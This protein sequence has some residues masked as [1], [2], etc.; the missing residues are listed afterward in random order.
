MAK[1][2]LNY[3]KE[4]DI[5]NIATINDVGSI[6]FSERGIRVG[7]GGSYILYDGMSHENYNKKILIDFLTFPENPN[8]D[9]KYV[10]PNGKEWTYDGTKWQPSSGQN[11]D[12]YIDKTTGKEY[13]YVDGKWLNYGATGGINNSGGNTGGG[14]V[15]GTDGTIKIEDNTLYTVMINDSLLSVTTSIDSLIS[16]D[17]LAINKTQEQLLSWVFNG[18]ESIPFVSNLAIVYQGNILGYIEHRST[19]NYLQAK[20]VNTE[21]TLQEWL[22]TQGTEIQNNYDLMFVYP[23]IGIKITRDLG[24]LRIDYTRVQNAEGF[25]YSAFQSGYEADGTTPIYKDLLMVSVNGGKIK[26]GRYYSYPNGSVFAWQFSEN[27]PLSSQLPYISA[28]N[29]IAMLRRGESYTMMTCW[30][31]RFIGCI[32]ALVAKKFSFLNQKQYGFPEYEFQTHT[33]GLFYDN[34]NKQVYFDKT[35][36]N[37][38]KM[39]AATNAENLDI[40][41]QLATPIDFDIAT[42]G[43]D[44]T[45][46]DG[47]YYAIEFYTSDNAPNNNN[48]FA[49]WPSKVYASSSQWTDNGAALDREGG[50]L[51]FINDSAYF[52]PYSN[53]FYPAFAV[54]RSTVAFQLLR[55]QPTS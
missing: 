44:L 54:Y 20:V 45:S 37:C 47:R 51:R 21:L 29:G 32:Y 26:D 52:C 28:K 22:A 55:N 15:G 23:R 14:T 5:G 16:H 10:D 30:A 27:R 41:K 50:G 1:I 42:I 33:Y 11:G 49:L 3:A 8:T 39:T 43:F 38:F 4:A 2:K 40:M 7:I 6:T 48:D 46:P 19:N 18:D 25:D 36:A 17:N 31:M 9:D 34:V 12:K 24:M 13:Y 53:S 35:P